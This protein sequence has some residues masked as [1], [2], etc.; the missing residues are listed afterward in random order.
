MPN[1]KFFDGYLCRSVFT[2]SFS[3]LATWIRIHFLDG[4][5]LFEDVIYLDNHS[6]PNDKLFDG[7][8]CRLVFTDSFSIL[9]TWIRIHFFRILFFFFTFYWFNHMQTK[10]PFQ[11][12]KITLSLCFVFFFSLI[13]QKFYKFMMYLYLHLFYHNDIFFQ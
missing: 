10:R 12:S 1:E 13:I 2:N 11:F 7:H 5:Q 6:P 4:T 3:I 8:L 9:V